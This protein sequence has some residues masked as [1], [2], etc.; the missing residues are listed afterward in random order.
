M[1]D[2]VCPRKRE[3]CTTGTKTDHDDWWPFWILKLGNHLVS[4]SCSTVQPKRIDSK[5]LDD[6][7]D[8]LLHFDELTEDDDSASALQ[9]LAHEFLE[10]L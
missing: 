8:S 10:C 9:G 1:D 2:R 6:L 7:N 3:A 4:I 5:L